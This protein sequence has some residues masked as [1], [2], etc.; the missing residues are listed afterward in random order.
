MKCVDVDISD[1]VVFTI[2]DICPRLKLTASDFQP[3]M[4]FVSDLTIHRHP[5]LIASFGYLAGMNVCR[6]L[7]IPDR[8][9]D[10]IL[11]RPW[12]DD[13]A[14]GRDLSCCAAHACPRVRFFSVVV[15]E[16]TSAIAG[17]HRRSINETKED[18]Q[19]NSD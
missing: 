5:R 8:L 12:M 10:Y 16:S 4:D 9:R 19:R 6:K 14:A 3:S 18:K 1:G 7:Y 13:R 2:D 15:S 11:R 17:G